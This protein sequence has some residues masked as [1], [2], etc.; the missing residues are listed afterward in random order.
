MTTNRFFISH[1]RTNYPNF[2]SSKELRQLS[3]R[4][5]IQSFNSSS[6]RTRENVFTLY[7]NL[8]YWLMLFIPLTVGGFYFT[9][10][11]QLQSSPRLI[12][13]HFTLMAAWMGIVIAQPLLIH[14]KKI[15]LHRKLGK[16]SY[17]LVPMLILTTWMVMRQSYSNQLATFEHDFAQGIAPYS[18]AEAG[19]IAIASFSAIAF[20]YLF[21]LTAFYCLAIFFR[22][23]T[24]IHARFMIAAALTFLGPTLDRVLFFWFDLSTIGFGISS[25]VI[26]FLL[27]DLI[28]LF[29]LIQD[30]RKNKSIFPF[31]FSLGLYIPFQIFFLTLT[32]T[33]RWEQIVSF[34]LG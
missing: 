27:I 25:V 5:K 14:H 15:I 33:S 24:S 10:F 2:I 1:F 21:W 7:P 23:H 29:L 17:V 30:A 28:L 11:T 16:L 4:L 32:E 8:E 9:Y 26:S 12:H 3:L 31:L 13:L 19:R 34:L 20:V 6:M 22:R 18:T